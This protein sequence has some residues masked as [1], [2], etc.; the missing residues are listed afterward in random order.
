MIKKLSLTALALLVIGIIGSVITYAS[1]NDPKNKIVI[2][3]SNQALSTIDINIDSTDIELIPVDDPAQAR[4]ELVGTEAKKLKEKFT[5]EQ[6]DNKLAIQLRYKIR[7]WTQFGWVD[8]LKV[9]VYLPE[10]KYE[11]ITIKGEAAD[12]FMNKVQAK[13]IHVTLKAGDVIGKELTPESLSIK[14]D[15]GDI[16]LDK[17]NGN[18]SAQLS[19]GDIAV[20]DSAISTLQIKTT[21]G[22]I[23]VKNVAGEITSSSSQ[24]DIHI[25]NEKIEHPI[26][27]KSKVGDIIVEAKKYP[28][29]AQ[30][31]ATSHVGDVIILGK[32]QQIINNSN[33]GILI[34]LETKTGDILVREK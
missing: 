26:S 29:N 25:N 16:R 24:G 2:P 4:V 9:K 12:L 7:K 18:V 11:L 28:K 5:V 22:D 20:S 23:H 30:F 21:T 15:V 8:Q 34:Q 17:I 32:K 3:I 10:K 6:T 31:E 19:A 27:I 1:P 13:D 33:P 14:N